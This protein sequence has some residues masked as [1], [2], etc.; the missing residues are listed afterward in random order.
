MKFVLIPFLFILSSFGF[1]QVVFDKTTHDFGDI[2]GD[3]PRYVDFYLKNTTEKD[4]Y[5]LS[6]GNPMDVVFLKESDLI[7]T[8]KSTIIRFQINRRAKGKFS[9]TIPVYT[10]DKNEPTNIKIKGNIA[11]LPQR[12][13]FLACPNFNQKPADGNP[14]DFSL[15]VETIDKD[16]R[17]KLGKS[18]VAILQNGSA[19]GKWN[20]DKKGLLRLRI[21]LGISYFYATHDGYTPAELATY[22]N[23]KNNY[24]LLELTRKVT[25]EILPDLVEEE[26]IADVPSEVEPAEEEERTIEIDFSDVPSEGITPVEEPTIPE[27]VEEE[28]AETVLEEPIDEEVPAQEERVIE[29]DLNDVPSV[30]IADVIEPSTEEEKEEKETFIPPLLKELDE[31]DFSNENFNPI[32]VTFVIDIS[33][34]MN[35]YGR[36]DLLKY[37]LNEVTKMIRPQDKVGMVAYSTDA[38][39]IMESTAGSQKE[40]INESVRKIKAAGH[41]NGAAGIKLGYKNLWKNR[42]NSTQNHLIIITDGAFNKN[43]GNYKKFIQK[44]FDKKGMTMSVIGIKSNEKA[45]ENMQEA[46]DLGKGRFILIENLSDAQ[47]K[48]KQEIRLASFKY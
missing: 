13:N 12:N 6:V 30:D 2:H 21:P 23:F 33:G 34:S 27:E 47:N 25:P 35:Q 8:D 24:V 1:S 11:S 28:I 18:K 7:S 20:T 22:V 39:I 44:N 43:T 14:L 9:Y 38:F 36:L 48:L 37:A 26:L 29:I 45:E 19:I 46:A 4:A 31:N 42:T 5:V 17:E 15:I 3:E 41:T 40:Q 16:T 32:N 10:S